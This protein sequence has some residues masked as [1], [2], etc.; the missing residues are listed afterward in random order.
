MKIRVVPP[1]QLSAD[2]LTAWSRLQQSDPAFFSPFF[3][4]E[5][6]QAVAAVRGDVQVA[7][8]EQAGEPVGFLPFQRNGRRLGLPVGSPSNDFQ[9][10]IA[11]A[12]VAWSPQDVVRAAGLRSWQFDHLVASQG[13]FAPFQYVFGRSPYIDLSQGLEHYLK[14][15]T[16][17][18]RKS[19]K[20]YERRTTAFGD[21]RLE[22]DSPDR[23]ALATLVK[24]KSD[25]C[26][27]TQVPCSFARG[28]TVKLLDYILAHPA[29]HFS[30]MVLCLYLGDRIAALKFAL[31]SGHVLHEWHSAYN[32]DMA[33]CSPGMHMENLILQNANSLG[34]TRID[35]GKGEE[36][37]KI[38]LAT[39]FVPLAEGA[40]HARP[41]QA[42]V[43]RSWFRTKDRLRTTALRGPVVRARRWML[44]TRIW[45][46]YTE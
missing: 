37:D 5:F 19:L 39:D 42:P 45:L 3:R 20:K 31:R 8:W 32:V 15:R 7:V 41:L 28:W 18:F 22:V 13:G 43:Y 26:R 10:A 11:R 27:R 6:T 2:D 35:L 30:G 12:D 44:Q 24:W 21:A 17:T 36:T 33:E 16:K 23:Q 40:V 25:K 1:H 38:R 9:G 4:P 14:S 29:E 34:I 46:G